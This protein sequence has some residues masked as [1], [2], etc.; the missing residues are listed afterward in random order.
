LPPAQLLST[1]VQ[2]VVQAVAPQMYGA[3]PTV[4]WVTQLPLLAVPEQWETRVAVEPLQAGD[5]QLTLLAAW[6][7]APDPV[8]VPVFPQGGLAAQRPC[9][10]LRPPVTLA[11]VPT[12]LML[13][14]WQVPQVPVEQQT[15]SM[16][17]PLPHSWLLPQEVPR[18]LSAT[19][20]PFEAAVQ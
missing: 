17:L 18:P 8:Q 10:S 11:H 2:V 13:Q 19:Q 4:G 12:P 6:V 15:P 5:P 14:A 3:Q 16:Q 1:P 9:G 20:V 7:Q